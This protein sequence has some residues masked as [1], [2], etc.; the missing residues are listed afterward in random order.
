MPEGLVRGLGNVKKVV[1]NP[2]S[3]KH[4]V[5][6][7]ARSELEKMDLKN[8]RVKKRERTMRLK[9][10]GNDI[11]AAIVHHKEKGNGEDEEKADNDHIVRLLRRYENIISSNGI[12]D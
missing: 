12:D 5:I 2:L 9:D 6:V 10:L 3:I 11:M 8:V 1:I 4:D 7:Y